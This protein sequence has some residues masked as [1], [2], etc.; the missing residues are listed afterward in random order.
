MIVPVGLALVILGLINMYYHAYRPTDILLRIAIP[1]A[2]AI[3]LILLFL[4]LACYIL[5]KRR[6]SDWRIIEVD[7]SVDDVKILLESS[8]PRI[9]DKG[10]K[11]IV[12]KNEWVSAGLKFEGLGGTRVRIRAYW[13]MP[14]RSIAVLAVSFVLTWI[15][16][17][18][19]AIL[20]AR[21]ARPFMND[22]LGRVQATDT[23]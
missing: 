17:I 19:V 3:L 16:P 6:A 13:H 20:Y 14:R 9:I 10:N 8:Y 21:K 4:M 11:V 12:F 7:G 2:Y 23:V 18:V 15:G 5:T 22:L 1:M